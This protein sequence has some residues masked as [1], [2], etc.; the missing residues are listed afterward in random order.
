MARDPKPA[1]KK[2]HWWNTIADAYRITRR[3][4]KALAWWMLGAGV[5]GLAI[6]IV[7]A[8][9]TKSWISWSILGV[10]LAVT[11]PMLLLV[12][13]VKKASY[14]QLDGMP[15]ASSAVLDNLGRG[16]D[17]KQEPVRFNARTQEMVFRAIG[18]PGVV[19]VTEGGTVRARKL[20]DDERRAIRRVAPNAPIHTIMV[21]HEEHQVTLSKLD[22][23]IRK[24]PKSISNEEVAALSRR[25]ESINPNN[26]PI[27]KGIDPTNMR[28]NRRALR[29][30]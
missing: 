18:R 8:F 13:L 23:T 28:M 2:K 27:P 11:L 6:G 10:L 29:G 21:G 12:Q 30:R 9:L 7:P 16:W 15:G 22:R 3:T 4:Y 14:A 17:V 1:Q 26:L 20:L 5:L 25:L 19:L 24:L